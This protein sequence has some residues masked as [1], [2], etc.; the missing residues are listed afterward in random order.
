MMGALLVSRIGGM[1]R[2]LVDEEM[3]WP[4]SSA[5]S[6]F[7]YAMAVG[8]RRGWLDG[9]IYRPA[10]EKAGRPFLPIST[11]RGIWMMSAP[12]PDRGTIR[13][14]ILPGRG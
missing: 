14:T 1:W 11:R 4:E 12:A 8:C 10:V 3:A 6:M 9:R 5:T 2:Q 7:A 13:L